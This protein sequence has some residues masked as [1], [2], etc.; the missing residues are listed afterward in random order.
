MNEICNSSHILEHP[1][2]DSLRDC[3]SDVLKV[4]NVL[5]NPTDMKTKNLVLRNT[6]CVKLT[7]GLFQLGS[8]IWTEGNHISAGSISIN[9]PVSKS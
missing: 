6:S 9:Q 2:I 3:R 5:K 1:C 7:V 4:F 8:R